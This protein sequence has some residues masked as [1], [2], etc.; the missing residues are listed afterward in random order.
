MENVQGYSPGS[1]EEQLSDTVKSLE[2]G[3]TEQCHDE[4]RAL[5]EQLSH[6]EEQEQLIVE[7]LNLNMSM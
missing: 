6:F 4:L 1:Q 2:L 7:E 3:S 5:K